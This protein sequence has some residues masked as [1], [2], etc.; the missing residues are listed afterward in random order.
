MIPQS[1]G[2]YGMMGKV[3]ATFTQLGLSDRL[4]K[5]VDRRESCSNPERLTGERRL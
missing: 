5:L 3:I 4:M 2:T 1:T